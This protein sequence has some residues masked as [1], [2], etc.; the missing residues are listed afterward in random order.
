VPALDDDR[1]PA[2]DIAA[3]DELIATHALE[4]ACGELVK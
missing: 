4:D 2:P 3:I 1:A